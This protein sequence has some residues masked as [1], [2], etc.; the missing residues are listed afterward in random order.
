MTFE[1]AQA[2]THLKMIEHDMNKKNCLVALLLSVCSLAGH[3]APET[4][5]LSLDRNK[6]KVWTYKTA[7][8]PVFQY[9]AETSF[10]VPMEQAVAVVLDVE[11]TPQWV[12]Y[13]GKAQVLSRDDK[14]GEFTLYMVLD[15]PFP[16]KDR[17]LIIQGEMYK[18]ANGTIQ[19]KNKVTQQGKA[20]NPN[21]IRLKKYEGDWT[22]NQLSDGKIK[23]VTTGYADPEGVIPQSVTNM[24]VQ[25]QPYQMLQKMKTELAKP[26]R[27]F[28]HLPTI[29]K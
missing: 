19:I 5:K 3:A 9:K 18:D 8:N 29:L 23:V 17:D 1:N 2:P 10:D 6:I 13:V 22:F 15:F 27:K 20:L 12:P 16:L 21:Y 7:N 24:F 4:A 25:Q 28:P 11:R 26:N 14:K